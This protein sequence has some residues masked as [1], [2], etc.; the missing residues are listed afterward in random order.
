MALVKTM[1]PLGLSR[2]PSLQ[3]EV[4]AKFQVF[5]RDGRHILQVNTYGSP[6]REIPGKVS[7]TLQFGPEGIAQ[8]KVI[9]KSIP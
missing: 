2:T 5:E 7:Q 1:S 6:E 4:E 8:L 3:G 9:L